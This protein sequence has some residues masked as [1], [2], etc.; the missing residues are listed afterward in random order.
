MGNSIY[1]AKR[2]TN[3]LTSGRIQTA[4]F[5]GIPV[6]YPEKSTVNEV[7][8]V[9]EGQY[10]DADQYPESK[11]LILG[12]KGHEIDISDDGPGAPVPL[13]HQPTDVMPWGIIPLVLRPVDKDLSDD[14]RERYALRIL[15]EHHGTRYWAYYAK[16]ISHRGKKTQDYLV[17][18]RD[19]VK[20]ITEFRYDDTHQYPT[21]P[22]LPD[23][24]YDTVEQIVLAD[25]D[26]VYTAVTIN[27]LLDQFDIDELT[28]MARIKY[29]SP[30]KAVVSE[31]CL[32]SGVDAMTQ[33]ESMVGSPFQYLEVKACQINVFMT[34]FNNAAFSNGQIAYDIQIGQTEPLPLL[35]GAV[36]PNVVS[37]V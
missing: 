19:G 31:F 13:Q 34:T 8:K 30:L 35:T 6:H 24:N 11:F 26:Y 33:G 32:A 23:Y 5:L 7:L 2:T 22:K 10:P 25:G 20:T 3:T 28:N 4:K 16:R 29:K 14:V 9:L 1:E 21:P 17:Q 37:N 15:E 18:V 36:N 27:V 12:N